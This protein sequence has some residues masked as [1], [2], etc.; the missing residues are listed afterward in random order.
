MSHCKSS[1]V[2]A[3]VAGAGT[4]S[5]SLVLGPSSVSLVLVSVGVSVG[6]SRRSIST[7]SAVALGGGGSR[8]SSTS[9][10]SVSV[11]TSRRST[12]MTSAV[13]VGGGG[14]SSSSVCVSNGSKSLMVCWAQTWSVVSQFELHRA[15]VSAENSFGRSLDFATG[16]ANAASPKTQSRSKF[17]L[18]DWPRKRSLD[19]AENS[20][21]A[22]SLWGADLCDTTRPASAKN[23]LPTLSP[24]CSAAS[25]NDHV[26]CQRGRRR[27]RWRAPHGRVCHHQT[28]QRDRQGQFQ[29]NVCWCVLV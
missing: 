14:S 3:V 16:L 18:G 9:L 5:S 13:A 21:W 25:L 10:V 1:V 2:A 20:L 22:F 23:P 8:S 19:R 6:T 12:S 11:G 27:A 7:T 17:R 28:R 26:S 4:S 29:R 24:V 15:R